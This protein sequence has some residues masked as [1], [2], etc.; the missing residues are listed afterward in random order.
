MKLFA[1]LILASSALTASV[2]YGQQLPSPVQTYFVPLPEEQL[3]DSFKTLFPGPTY[4][5]ASIPMVRGNVTNAISVAVASDGTIVYYDHWEDGYEADVA[6]PTQSTT[7]VWGDGKISNGAPP[8]VTTDAEDIL[9][10]GM[11]IVL[12][13][14]IDPTVTRGPLDT[15]YDGRD[16]IQASL[17]IAVTRFAY[18]QEPGSLMAG[19]VEVFELASWGRLFEAPVGIDTISQTVSVKW[20]PVSL[21]F[22]P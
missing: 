2:V 6:N 16:R 18:P 12:E 9:T 5:N 13:D 8:G 17:P 15:K 20:V 22:I 3:F 11:A 19:A 10:G 4:Y 14:T 21:Y 1:N 7:E